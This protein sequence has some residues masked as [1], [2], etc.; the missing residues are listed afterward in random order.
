[1]QRRLLQSSMQ[2]DNEISFLLV[3][4]VNQQCRTVFALKVAKDS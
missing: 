3:L 1:M 2:K 4:Y